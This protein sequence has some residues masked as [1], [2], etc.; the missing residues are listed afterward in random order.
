MQ[1]TLLKEDFL[2]ML[3]IYLVEDAKVRG[4]DLSNTDPSELSEYDQLIAHI[5]K[6]PM[7]FM[8]KNA[9]FSRNVD[10]KA[11][12]KAKQIVKYLPE[13]EKVVTIIS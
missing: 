4:K 1:A 11:R 2:D 13:A 8:L 10:P 5:G 9:K 3:T 7:K 6:Y 12:F